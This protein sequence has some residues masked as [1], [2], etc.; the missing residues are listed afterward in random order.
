MIQPYQLPITGGWAVG[1]DEHKL[2]TLGDEVVTFGSEQEAVNYCKVYN[3]LDQ[4]CICPACGNTWPVKWA[5]QCTDC[6]AKVYP[7][8]S[9]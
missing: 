4:I 3:Y 8:L 2:L 1:R 6:D 9:D 5:T 7:V